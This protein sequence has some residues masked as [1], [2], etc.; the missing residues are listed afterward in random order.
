MVA[1]RAETSMSNILKE[2]LSQ[3]DT[4]RSLLKSLYKSEAD[5]IPNEMERT[6][7][8]R[9]HHMANHASDSA[10]KK[11]CSELN[12]TETIFPRTDLRTIFELGSSQN[13]RDQEF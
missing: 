9:L 7:T 5:L 1:Y 13:H 2:H 6:L 12:A 11:M 10:I 4:S 3:P 8:V